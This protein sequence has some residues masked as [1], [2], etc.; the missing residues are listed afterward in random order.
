M[1]DPGT[2]E[3]LQWVADLYLKHRVSPP[4]GT[5]FTPDDFSSGQLALKSALTGSVGLHLRAGDRE[6][7]RVGAGLAP[8]APQTGKRA[9]SMNG[10]PFMLLNP[11]QTTGK[12]ADAAWLLLRHMAGPYVQGLIGQSRD[13]DAHLIAAAQDKAT[14]GRRRRRTCSSTTG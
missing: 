12:N 6:Q 14:F 11:Q 1:D 2:L 10:N 7:L 3:G 9:G 8:E 13:P 5:K 4:V